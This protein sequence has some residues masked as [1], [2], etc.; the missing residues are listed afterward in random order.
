MTLT[1]SPIKLAIGFFLASGIAFAPFTPAR[2]IPV[3]E[4]VTAKTS[5]SLMER[6]N[7]LNTLALEKWKTNAWGDIVA[8]SQEVLRD[9]AKSPAKEKKENRLYMGGV[10]YNLACAFALSKKPDDAM[11]ALHRAVEEFGYIEYEH[12]KADSDLESL[13]GR[14][15][16]KALLEKVRKLGDYLPILKAAPEYTKSPD[17]S[18]PRV[19]YENK[20]VDS[21]RSLR[22]QYNLDEVAG[23]G[24]EVSRL[25]NLMLWVNRQVDHDGS[26]A[27]PP[28]RNAPA[29]LT[30]AKAENHGLNCRMM[31]TILNDVFLA[32]GFATRH[33]TCMP[34]N[35]DDIDCHVINMVYSKTL[36]KWVWMDASFAGYWTDEAGNLLSISEVREHIRAGKRVKAGDTLHHNREKYTEATYLAYMTKNLYWFTTPIESRFDYETG[37]SG[38]HLALVPPGGK[39]G[40]DGNMYYTS[41]PVAFWAKP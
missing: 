28:R 32:E 18:A 15:D 4:A 36:K 34:K 9:Y 16:F 35:P 23:T 38:H 6:A 40:W 39:H 19:S 31:S 41:D 1:R 20:N 24:D 37:G 2:A 29:L 33:V 10:A 13:H 5:L 22:E 26:S 14:S 12:I 8:P 21:L 30:A 3:Q 7:Q 25:K 11:A 27:P 17:K